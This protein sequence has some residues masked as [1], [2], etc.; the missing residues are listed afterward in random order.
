MIEKIIKTEEEWQKILT[1]EQFR[2]MRKRKTEMPFTCELKECKGIGVYHCAACDLPLFK[3]EVIFD[4]GTGWPSF[5]EPVK[6]DHLILKNDYSL[7]IKRVE[8]MCARCESHLGHLFND[9]TKE[10]NLRYCINSL[11]LKFKA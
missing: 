6:S 8:V 4:S 2:I 10:T 1:P 7:G 9:G 5:Y 3:S 11:V